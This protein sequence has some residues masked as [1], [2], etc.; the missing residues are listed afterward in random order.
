[1]LPGLFPLVFLDNRRREERRE[2]N[3]MWKKRGPGM[4]MLQEKRQEE[5]WLMD[6]P[7]R[8]GEMSTIR[9]AEFRRNLLS[10]PI[11]GATDV[12]SKC[13][14]EDQVLHRKINYV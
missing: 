5:W 2:E 3:G 10:R 6:G 8:F 1:M 9:A 14:A 13:T 7:C 11:S 4:T 12:S